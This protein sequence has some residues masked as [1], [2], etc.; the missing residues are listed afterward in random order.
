MSEVFCRNRFTNQTVR[1]GL[2][3]RV[4]MD[5]MTGW[6]L[7]HAEQAR[8]A[9]RLRSTLRPKFL[10]G[11]SREV[12]F[13]HIRQIRLMFAGQMDDGNYCVHEHTHR[14]ENWNEKEAIKLLNRTGVLHVR[15]CQRGSERKVDIE[16]G[17]C[18]LARKAAGWLTNSR[19]I[20]EELAE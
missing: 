18:L 4:A 9:E 10:M 12:A 13:E 5:F 15:R 11:S 2:R 17:Y 7:G 14:V 16:P 6:D 20:A 1:W 3:P 8:E 19:C